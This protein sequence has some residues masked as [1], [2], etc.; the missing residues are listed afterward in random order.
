MARLLYRLKEGVK[1]NLSDVTSLKVRTRLAMIAL[2][3]K[4]CG[5]LTE[6]RDQSGSK[7]PSTLT[8]IST[9]QYGQLVVLTDECYELFILLERFRLKELSLHSLITVGGLLPGQVTHDM[10]CDPII[11]T[12]WLAITMHIDTS[13]LDRKLKLDTVEGEQFCSSVHARLIK[14]LV[15]DVVNRAWMIQKLKCKVIKLFMKS[16]AR[17]FQKYVVRSMQLNKQA[18]LRIKITQRQ[19]KRSG[20]STCTSE[21]TQ[22]LEVT[23]SSPVPS[24]SVA[25][26]K[27]SLATE[28]THEEGE[29][30][31]CQR[32]FGSDCDWVQ[33]DG[34]LQWYCRKC[35]NLGAMGWKHVSLEK[36]PWICSLCTPFCYECEVM[37]GAT[38]VI[39]LGCHSWFCKSCSNL[40]AKEWQE[41]KKSEIWLCARCVDLAFD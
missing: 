20:K 29:C 21:S 7:Y 35:C 38:Y 4:M 10:C 33:C 22:S 19:K 5:S 25:H 2:L 6:L 32:P 14:P 30:H 41:V 8:E 27:D 3:K 15:V 16:A 37:L 9:R 23:S 34:C 28:D 26:N 11:N 18:A 39:C 13:C 12:K 1:G 17:S 24:T 40:R 36:Q 31:S